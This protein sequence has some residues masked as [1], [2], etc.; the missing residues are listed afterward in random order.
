MMN[1]KLLAVVTPL[2]IYHGCSTQKTFWEET[3]TG[4]EKLFSTV[5]MKNCGLCNVRK[6]NEIKGSDKYITLD[7]S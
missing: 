1:M 2:S 4:E 5:N 7:I 6:H 3:F